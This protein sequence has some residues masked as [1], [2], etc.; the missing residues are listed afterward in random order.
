MRDAVVT[1]LSRVVLAAVVVATDFILAR[2]LGPA[3]KGR[4]T[5]ILLFSQLAALVVGLGLDRALG[6]TVARSRQTARS[7]FANA[8]LW[9]AVIGGLSVIASLVAYGVPGSSQFVP[10]RGPLTAVLPNLSG[11]QFLFAALALPGELFFSLGLLGLLGRQ[12]VLEYNAVRVLRRAVLLLL[13]VAVAAIASL[14]LDIVLVLNLLALVAAGGIVV[15]SAAREGVLGIRPD[16]PLLGEQLRFGLRS[17]VGT[18]AER[19]LFRADA[20]LLNLFIGPVAT[21]VY[22]VASGLAETLWY[23][24]HAVGSV[25]FSRAVG[26]DRQAN[27]VATAL[28]R[29]TIALELLAAVPVLLLAPLAVE[30]VYGPAFVEA[31]FALRAMLPGVVAYGLVAVLSQFIVARGAPGR[32]TLV[33]SLGLAVNVALNLLLIPRLGTV[34]AG[35][36]SSASYILTAVFVLIVFQ[37]LSGAGL[38]ETLVLR[39]EDV[40]PILDRVRRGRRGGPPRAEQA[41]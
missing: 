11:Q 16:A 35:L 31:G 34:G 17:V 22:S 37:R 41:S 30:I 3:A 2:A 23:L 8:I 15:W 33:L 40:A 18:L 38:R 6:V 26:E 24:P 13:M 4:L 21:G 28:A 36:A 25:L 19:L 29:G 32:Y 5:L 39:R 9:T 10:P 20:F 1:A 14:S 27:R 7:A 12:R